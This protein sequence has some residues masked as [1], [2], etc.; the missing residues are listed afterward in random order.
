MKLEVAKAEAK[1]ISD[2]IALQ[3]KMEEAVST[4]LQELEASGD[5]DGLPNESKS[6][7]DNGEEAEAIA[8]AMVDAA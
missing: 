8:A 6:S 7:S 5:A 3:K 2:A 4:R 1:V